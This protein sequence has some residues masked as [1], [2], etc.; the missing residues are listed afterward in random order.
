MQLEVGMTVADA[1]RRLIEATVKD[2]GDDKRAAAEVLGISLRTLY[3]RL[4]EYGVADGE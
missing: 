1:E 2:R 4:R 3:N